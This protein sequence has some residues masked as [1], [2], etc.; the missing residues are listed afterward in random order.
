MSEQ[1]KIRKI[2]RCSLRTRQ[3]GEALRAV[4]QTGLEFGACLRRQESLHI[5]VKP[6]Q[7]S[8]DVPVKQVRTHISARICRMSVSSECGPSSLHL[9]SSNQSGGTIR[10]VHTLIRYCELQGLQSGQRAYISACLGD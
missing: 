2:P 3:G 9:L 7:L 10:T 4:D 1:F 6:S 5:Q 8:P